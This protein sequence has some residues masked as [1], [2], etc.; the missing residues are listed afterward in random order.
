MLRII[1]THWDYLQ[2]AQKIGVRVVNTRLHFILFFYF[3]S[4]FISFF[5]STLPRVRIEYDIIGH[6]VQ[7]QSQSQNHV[8]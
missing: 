2:V 4:I 6:I 7:S 8:I 1:H 5:I 3:I